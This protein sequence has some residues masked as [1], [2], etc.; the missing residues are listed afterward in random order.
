M[1]NAITYS[2][3]QPKTGSSSIIFLGKQMKRVSNLSSH[4]V[5]TM[6]WATSGGKK[7]TSMRKRSRSWWAL[8]CSLAMVA[9]TFT[10]PGSVAADPC[11]PGANK[12]VCENS[13]P[14]T[15]PAIWDI[16]GA[17]DDSIQGFSTDISANVGTKINFKI[18]TNASAYTI[19][20]YRTGWYQGLGA[21]KIASVTPSASLPQTQPACRNDV[22]TELV[23]CGNWG[24][25]ASWN[26]PADAVSGVYVAK[27]HRADRDDS[28]HITFIVRD[29][30][31]HSDILFQTSDPTWHAYNTYGGSDFYQG[32]ANGRAYKL[33][34]NR[35]F[36]TRGGIEA[37]DFY[38]GNEYPLVRFMERN[39][40]DVSYF[41]GVDTDRRGDLL[42]NHKVALS[43]GHD[44]YWS[45]NQWKN[46]EKAR[47]AGVNIQFLSGNEAYWRTRYEASATDGTA[48]RTMVSYKETWSYAKVD[49]SSEWTGTFRDPRYAPASAGAATPENSLT[50][51]L[52]MVNNGDLPVTVSAQ[53]GKSRLWRGTALTS[54]AAGTKRALAPHTIGYES[55]ESP[56]N[57]FRP[58]GQ[59]FL[60]TTTGAVPE[61]LQ[62]FG[63]T[64]A[65]GNTTHHLSL[66]KAASGALVFSAGSIQWTWGLDQEH[67]GDGAPADPIMQ[68]AQVNLFAD[69]GAQPSTLMSGLVPASK[70]T[71]LT[72]PSIN[73]TTAPP[74]SPKNGKTYTVAGTAMDSGGGVV[75]GVEY[76]TDAGAHWHPA[77]GT[78]NWTF[79]YVQSGKDNVSLLVRGIDDSGNYP[80][81][82]T[83]LPLNVAGPYS[84]FGE[85]AP[86]I[87]DS[88]DGSSVELG[89]RFTPTSNG[90]ITGVRFYKSAANTG[91]HTGTLWSM[92]G[93]K[94]STLTFTGES[95]SGWQEAKF[96]A[97]VEV[98]AGTEYVVSY[99]TSKGHYSA[100]NYAWAYSGIVADPLHV[101]GGFGA[102]PAGVYD[103]GGNMPTSSFEQGNYFVDAIFESQDNSALSAYSQIPANTAS[104]VPVST[105]IAATLSKPVTPSSVK[106][107]LK[108]SAGAPVAGSTSY[109]ALTRRAT[110][111]PALSLSK[112]TTY[113]ATL[114]ATDALG[115]PVGSGSSWSF[116]TVKPDTVPD[117]CPCGLYQDSTLPTI[118][119]IDDGTPLTLGMRLAVTTAGTV[120]GVKFYKA[121]GNTGP[122]IGKLFSASGAVLATVTFANET[123][124]GW[125]YAAFSSP[126]SVTANTE[127]TVAYTSQG[128]YSNTPGG[129]GDGISVGPINTYFSSGSYTY[130]DGFP[131]NQ[132]SSSYL[133]DIAFSPSTAQAISLV[134]RT[135]ISGAADV[136]TTSNVSA[137]FN[138]PLA[139]GATIGVK[140]GTTTIPGSVGLSSD[141][142]T[143]TFSPSSQ[144][145][146]GK[147][148]TV[149]LKNIKSAQGSTLAD[150]TWSFGTASLD[151]A[152]STF[153]GDTVPQSMDPS[154]TSSVE[155]GLRLKTSEDIDISAIR[156]YKGAVN[157]G[158]HTGSLW[159]ESG[160]L[161]ATVTFSNE[162]GTGW[163]SA[164]LSNPV[165]LSANTTFIVSYLAPNGGYA[166]TSGDFATPRSVGPLATV[167]SNGL[168]VY[169]SGGVAPSNTWGNTNYF[170][171]VVFKI[172]TAPLS[173][174]SPS[175]EPTPVPTPTPPAPTPTPIPTPPAPTPTPTPPAPAL[176]NLFGT[177]QPSLLDSASSRSIEVGLRFSTNAP[178]KATGLRFYKATANTGTHTGTLWN[179]SG[180]SLGKVT[181]TGET[182]QGWQSADFATPINLATGTYTISYLAPRGHVSTTASFFA[183]TFTDGVITAT[184]SNGRY[185]YGSGGTMPASTSRNTNYFV[186]LIYSK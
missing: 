145:P 42:T 39:G 178:I 53:E 93:Q 172:A 40:Y 55:D 120:N 146:A 27:L 13:K 105:A 10:A 6:P 141:A 165:H 122:H 100:E 181:F 153:L 144:L 131:N 139:A 56:D 4:A 110:F 103:T 21:R 78:S 164:T 64:V 129:L 134:S 14:G 142:R 63:N 84:V 26:I 119:L 52:Y 79:S 45:G 151:G 97:P 17:G 16:Q 168:F 127:Y 38:F 128:A 101:A 143:L 15:D 2:L 44:E 43:V 175:A 59:I 32:A 135:P 140:D 83:V 48:Y 121:S 85:K 114:S 115:N 125:Q 34:Y 180:Q 46:F 36:N 148:L 57:G 170:V 173:E 137:A 5:H 118:E 160:S 108:T 68:Q 98:N 33:S 169:G 184:T 75:A 147:N 9:V 88:G 71:D 66:Y 54:L 132:T 155:L 69:M 47:D 20:I 130:S 138:Q 104:S 60:S 182:A 81:T 76:S 8:V 51:T 29:D 28:S 7:A 90:F 161:L 19:D 94:L 158:T 74:A 179:S 30:S 92:A 106:I 70:S 61:Y 12:I 174:P 186:D 154:D 58:A 126:V 150:Q 99:S 136:P 25:S 95:A 107:V 183:K 80:A 91:T 159:S 50:G 73:I 23:D 18:N 24:I 123:A 77:T 109:D 3:G 37:R 167:G 162:T 11:A 89:L 49:P 113:T 156:F 163:Q 35:P 67:D 65:A 117:A 111:T 62:D 185:R 41:S 87:A 102:N 86:K 124:S 157:T 96:S 112:E 152:P 176:A 31:S 177:L 149:E 171:D 22:S 166:F 116:A 82:A 133:V 72:A 1:L